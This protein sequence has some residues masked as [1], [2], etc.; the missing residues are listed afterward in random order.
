MEW[1]GPLRTA[2]GATRPA[3]AIRAVATFGRPA[4]ELVGST[5]LAAAQCSVLGAAVAPRRSDSPGEVTVAVAA[6]RRRCLG[7]SGG[8]RLRSSGICL[9]GRRGGP[10]RLG[11][12][13]C[14]CNMSC[15]GQ[16]RPASVG[17]FRC[18]L[19]RSSRSVKAGPNQC[20][21]Q[22][23]SGDGNEPTDSRNPHVTPPGGGHGVRPSAIAVMTTSQCDRGQLDHH[24][25]DISKRTVADC[26]H[27]R[28][29]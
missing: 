24:H 10:S 4:A 2:A 16:L 14:A 29:G 21:R 20:G 28:I 18:V 22:Y 5:G 19:N 11:H 25:R 23:Q 3:L 6:R 17:G 8:R 9:G 1:I 26:A 27:L 13:R 7:K 12:R 15:L